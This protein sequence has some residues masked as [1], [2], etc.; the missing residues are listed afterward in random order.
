M[1]GCQGLGIQ[2][3]SGVGEKM[4]PCVDNNRT[5]CTPPS[6]SLKI[7]NELGG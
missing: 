3:S 1:G 5:I 4:F 7:F 6:I 2:E